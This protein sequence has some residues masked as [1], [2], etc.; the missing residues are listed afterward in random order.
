MR[1]LL[2]AALL[3]SACTSSAANPTRDLPMAPVP[4]PPSSPPAPGSSA[5]ASQPARAPDHPGAWQPKHV[6]VVVEENHSYRDVIGSPFAPYMNRLARHGASL[7]NMHAITHPSEP[8]YL[9]LFSGS[10]QGVIGDP[11]PVTRRSRTLA[12]QLLHAHRTFAGYSEGLPHTGSAVCSRGNYVRRHAP[13]TNFT[14]VPA[15]VGRPLR[16]LPRHYGNLP[17]VSFVIPDL[18]H[19]MHD[20]TIGQADTWLRSHLGAYVTWART[21]DSVLVLTWDEDDLG[22]GNHIPTVIT[23][24]HVRPGRYATHANHYRLLRTLEWLLGLPGISRSKAVAPI[25]QVWARS[26]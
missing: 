21:H 26:G 22:I 3:L 16:K 5:S 4:A 8:N 23:G 18:Q 12:N 7:T 19:D 9:A 17:D 10:T 15:S 14:N 6:V 1:V 24:S 25:T 2:A 20:G 11:C 13:W